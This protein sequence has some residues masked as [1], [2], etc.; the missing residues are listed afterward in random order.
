MTVISYSDVFALEFE[1]HADA[2]LA[3][4]DIVRTG[5]NLFPHYEVIAVHQDKVWLRD[6]QTAVDHLV[7]LGRCHR[8]EAP[9]LAI[10]A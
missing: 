4:G 2:R 5:G 1:H 6:L 9:N 10:A 7:P 8:I 3:A